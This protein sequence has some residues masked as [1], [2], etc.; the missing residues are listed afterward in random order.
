MVCP[1]VRGDNPRARG[2]SPVQMDEPCSISVVVSY[3]VYVTG[4]LA[5]KIRV[6]GEC[7]TRLHV[8]GITRRKRTWMDG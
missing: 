8:F 1:P 5:L 2:L 6:S 7:A 4:Y 3:P